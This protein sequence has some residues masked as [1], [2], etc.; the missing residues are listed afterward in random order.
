MQRL[1][2]EQEWWRNIQRVIINVP[3]EMMPRPYINDGRTLRDI[4]KSRASR[5]ESEI[6]GRTARKMV[7]RDGYR[8]E[9]V[10][11]AATSEK[12][13]REFF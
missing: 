7:Y 13:D 11:D 10:V 1:I 5:S 12:G 8:F 2:I 6:D 3:R 9:K 4:N